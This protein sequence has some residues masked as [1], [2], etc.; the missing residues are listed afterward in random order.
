MANAQPFPGDTRLFVEATDFVRG[1]AVRDTNNY[2][3]DTGGKGVIIT[4]GTPVHAEWE[5]SVPSA[6]RYQI[7]IRYAGEEARPVQLLVNGEKVTGKAA[8][9]A[10]GSWNA[11]GQQWEVAGVAPFKAGVN[12]VR[13]YRD[14]PLPHISRLLFFPRPNAVPATNGASPLTAETLAKRDNLIPELVTRF[15]ER[16]ALRSPT[17]AEQA[18]LLTD[19]T[20]LV[21]PTKPEPFYAE[22]DAIAVK[23]ATEALDAALKQAPKVP[24]VMAVEDGKPEDV[25]VHLR[26]STQTLGDVAPRG[27]PAMLAKSCAPQKDETIATNDTGS[28]RLAFARWLTRRDHPLTARVHVN[29]VW[30]HLLGEGLVRTPDNWG[31]KGEKP[32]H[33]ELLDY[34]T[35]TYTKPVNEGGDGWSQKRLIRR[36]MLSRTYQMASVSPSAQRAKLLDPANRFLWRQNRKR[37]E[38]E[39]LRDSVLAVAGTLDKSFG[40]SLLET[41][42]N[43]Y[44]T[45][46]Q[47]R[48]RALYDSNRRAVYLPVIRNS[49]YDLFQAFDFGDG[50]SVNARRASTV[51][52]PQALFLMNSPLARAAS[53]SFAQAVQ[54]GAKTEP[55]RIQAAYYRALSRP[56]TAAEVTQAQTYLTRYQTALASSEPDA[57]KRQTKAWQSLCHAL[58]ACNEFTYVD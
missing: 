41:P 24:V 21:L 58:L 43:E 29:R 40:G 5:V 26:G 48:D 6:G 23:S 45:N 30:Q 22:A 28:G 35:Q 42:N 36:I 47:S 54:A 13:V 33:P 20:L 50:M 31:V 57:Q 8:S 16:F 19:D 1:N 7:E 46:D 11:N 37:L 34:L 27:F 51:V 49:V 52:A 25:K 15:A 3:K 4:N 53:E 17:E 9:R 12:T 32:T 39:P 2:G 38:A 14:G 56:A 55:A 44:V 18:K 10:T